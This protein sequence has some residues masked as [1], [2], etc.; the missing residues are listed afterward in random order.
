MTVPDDVSSRP[1]AEQNLVLGSLCTGYGG[2]DLGVLA[3]LGGGRV[4]WVADPDPHVRTIL[5]TRA[6]GVPNLGDISTVDWDHVEEVDIITAGFPCQDISAAGKGLGIRK[7]ARSGIWRYVVEAVRRLRPPILIVENVAALRW[8]NGGLGAVLGDLADIGYDANWASVRASD[9]GAP[10][11]RERV[12]ILAFPQ[13]TRFIADHDT[14]AAT[15]RGRRP[16]A[17]HADRQRLA[18]LRAADPPKAQPQPTAIGRLAD[19]RRA[20]APHTGGQQP[21]RRR[22]TLDLARPSDDAQDQRNQ[23][24]R[25]GDAA[26]HHGP[27]PANP[28]SDR[29]RHNP[30]VKPRIPSTVEPAGAPS[31]ADTTCH[32]RGRRVAKTTRL[33]GRSDLVVDDPPTA[34]DTWGDYAPAI[35]R[36]ESSLGRAVPAPTEQGKQGRP[37]LAPRLVEWL[38]G[39]P[40]G[41]VTDLSLKRVAQLRALG[42]GVVPQ[43]AAYAVHLMLADLVTFETTSEDEGQAA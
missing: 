7:G 39:L 13:G 36:W 20:T 3:A 30:E 9:V 12:F 24:Q 33:K 26:L 23:R 43:Q 8:R 18:S 40:E 34:G 10:H 32:R 2:L 37:M 15:D 1:T 4:A 35:E 41:W 31:T 27:A 21:Q 22:I 11:R 17:A 5:A 6:P 42:N 19:R 28:E 38:M 14:G 25:H 16:T 29:P